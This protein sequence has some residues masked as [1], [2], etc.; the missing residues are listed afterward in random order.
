MHGE[1]DLFRV[2]VREQ[3]TA[4]AA[5]NLVEV[6]AEHYFALAGYRAVLGLPYD[7]VLAGEPLGGDR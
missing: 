2:N 1:S 3:Q 4:V 7:E 5:Q 6:L